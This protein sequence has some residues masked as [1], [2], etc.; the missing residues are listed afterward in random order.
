MEIRLIKEWPDEEIIALYKA[1][2]W[3]KDHYTPDNLADLIKGSFAFVVAVEN[4]KAIGM[5]R[6]I[7]DGVSDAWIQ[8]VAVMPGWR[9]KGIGRAIIRT[10]LDHCMEKG[11]CWVGLVAE[12]G[13]RKFYIPLG[14]KELPGEPMVY[15]PEA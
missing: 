7:S 1:G 3:W 13:T 15:E 8:D 6:A 12:P 10:L 14:F 9:G 4:G 11:L 5:G 2:G